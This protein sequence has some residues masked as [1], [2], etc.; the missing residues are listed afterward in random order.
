MMASF[1]V[2][3]ILHAGTDCGYDGAFEKRDFVAMN[4]VLVTGAGGFVGRRLLSRLTHADA[5]VRATSRGQPPA[6]IQDRME[7]VPA[8]LTE[9]SLNFRDL[10]AG[11]GSIVHLAGLAHRPGAARNEYELHNTIVTRRL[12]EA[13][14][15]TG[16]RH[17]LFVSTAKVHG[18]GFPPENEQEAYTGTDAPS[19]RD[20]YAAS[21]LEAEQALLDI[22]DGSVMRVTILRPP[23]IYGPGVRAN[24]LQLMRFIDK[25]VP[26]PL[27]SV[28]NRRSLMFVDNLCDLIARILES[29]VASSRVYGV[30]D[31]VLST[32]DLIRSIASGLSVSPKLFPFPL[33]LLQLAGR[34]TGRRGM[35]DRLTQSFVIDDTD[36]RRDF[37]WQPL[38]SLEEGMRV[39]GE[40]YRKATSYK[41]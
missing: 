41:L 29:P 6:F 34:L 19:P 40:W 30:S 36:V 32:P 2:P 28:E 10:C 35:V 17:F 9:E 11:C 25:G 18:E 20:D 39:T 23:L 1:V 27:A 33:A 14:V 8:D 24:F 7:W 22:A 12:G 4:R 5:E 16:V 3:D 31:A 26:L 38:V 15:N 21:K 37:H 13:A